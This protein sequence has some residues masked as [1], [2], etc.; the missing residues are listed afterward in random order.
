LTGGFKQRHADDLPGNAPACAVGLRP[1][2]VFQRLVGNRL[3]VAVAKYIQR[4]AKAADEL[5]VGHIW[6]RNTGQSAA[7][8]QGAA[9]GVHK[10]T[11]P[12]EM[13]GTQL[14]DLTDTPSG[15]IEMAGG[16]GV[17]VVERAKSIRGSLMFAEHHGVRVVIALGRDEAIRLIVEC[18]ESLGGT[19]RQI[20]SVWKVLRERKR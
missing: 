15:G 7:V 2:N 12:I 11:M 1:G 13:P 14:G 18:R 17:S 9:R 5:P 10:Q 8:N 16:A 3:D 6:H 19:W 20:H 4:S